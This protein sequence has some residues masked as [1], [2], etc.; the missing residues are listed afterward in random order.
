MSDTF[1]RGYAVLAVIRDN[2]TLARAVASLPQQERFDLIEGID[3]T[4]KEIVTKEKREAL[5]RI[6]NEI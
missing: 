6:A 2:P 5:L 3:M 1:P 4:V